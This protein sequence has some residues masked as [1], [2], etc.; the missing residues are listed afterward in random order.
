MASR[1]EGLQVLPGTH[2]VKNGAKGSRKASR[3][4]SHKVSRKAKPWNLQHLPL[5]KVKGF[6]WPKTLVWQPWSPLLEAPLQDAHHGGAGWLA[7][8]RG[9]PAVRGR[10]WGT[11]VP[12]SSSNKRRRQPMRQK[13]L[14]DKKRPKRPPLQDSR[15][16]STD[17]VWWH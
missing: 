13:K 17:F 3:K 14:K 1:K 11:L 4:V 12:D 10:W 15:G 8:T 7:M 6:P 9:F 16:K 2:P 5:R